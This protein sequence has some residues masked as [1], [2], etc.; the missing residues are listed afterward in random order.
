MGLKKRISAKKKV[1]PQDKNLLLHKFV[2]RYSYTTLIELFL[3]KDK[4]SMK[5]ASTNHHKW[6]GRIAALDFEACFSRGKKPNEKIAV[7]ANNGL[8]YDIIGGL[9]LNVE[10]LT[11]AHIMHECIHA[12]HRYN[13]AYI[14][15]MGLLNGGE[16]EE[17]VVCCAEEFFENICK[18]LDSHGFKIEQ[19][20]F[21]GDERSYIEI[22]LL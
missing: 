16:K 18:V 5:E 20:K 4:A 7:E 2:G 10:N 1:T 14:G 9:F 19:P 11:Y 6:G 12:A 21:S 22:D 13:I 17:V 8:E 3:Y 15:C